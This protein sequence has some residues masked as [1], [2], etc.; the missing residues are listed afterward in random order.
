[1]KKQIKTK[2]YNTDTSRFI[3][4]IGDRSLYLKK[5][6]ECFIC[7]TGGNIYPIDDTAAIDMATQAGCGNGLTEIINR[8]R[9]K[10]VQIFPFVSERV[11][12]DLKK[13]SSKYNINM[14]ESVEKTVD[15]FTQN[16][17]L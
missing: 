8:H 1:M 3:C 14:S 6:G 9:A 16:H 13:I 12:S 2:R 7:T 17:D 10:R 11:H 4:K 5:T 15:Y